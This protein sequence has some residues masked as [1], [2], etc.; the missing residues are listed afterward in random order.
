M[1]THYSIRG[2]DIASLVWSLATR[3]KLNDHCSPFQ[4]RLF[5]DS[6]IRSSQACKRCPGPHHLCWYAGTRQQLSLC[7]SNQKDPPT[8][9]EFAIHRT[10]LAVSTEIWLYTLFNLFP[11]TLPLLLLMTICLFLLQTTTAS[12]S[13]TIPPH[14]CQKQFWDAMQCTTTHLIEFRTGL[15]DYL[16]PLPDYFPFLFL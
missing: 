15:T 8:E 2:K 11:H 6:M 4:T 12:S 13:T 3:L 16:V 1:V 5:H 9:L 14:V 7:Q 10:L